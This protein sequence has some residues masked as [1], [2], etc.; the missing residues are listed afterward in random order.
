M[1]KHSFLRGFIQGGII[2][3]LTWVVSAC[4][5]VAQ[6]CKRVEKPHLV[7]YLPPELNETSGLQWVDSLLW[8]HNDKGNT[9]VLFSLCPVSGDLVSSIPV[10]TPEEKQ[11]WECLAACSSFLYIGN[12]GNN[13]AKRK[14]LSVYRIP[15]TDLLLHNKTNPMII[16]PDQIIRFELPSFLFSETK[17]HNADIEAMVYDDSLLVFFTKNRANHKTYILSIPAQ[18]GNHIPVLHDSLNPGVRITGADL[19]DS[20]CIWVGYNK[21]GN[22]Q[23]GY[24]SQWGGSH[25]ASLPWMQCKLG[26]FAEIG[27]VEGVAWAPDGSWYFT[28]EQ[29]KHAAA[30]LYRMKPFKENK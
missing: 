6:D 3:L 7:S 9:T 21:K 13:K 22:V 24:S 25:Y 27:Q 18:P 1:M 16:H 11:D 2:I 30:A 17:K 10:I 12:T 28:R 8:T 29:G 4:I 20:H 15:L 23:F 26:S 19:N 5:N 14:W